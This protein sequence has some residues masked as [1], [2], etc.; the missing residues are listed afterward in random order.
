MKIFNKIKEKLKKF[1][2]SKLICGIILVVIGL[3]GVFTIFF[4]EYLQY[5]SIQAGGSY[6]PSDTLP[7]TCV[8][9][10]LGT[11]AS[12]CLYQLGLK[13]SRNKY[14]I[15]S[16]GVPYDIKNQDIG[17]EKFKEMIT[18][19]VSER[20]GDSLEVDFSQLENDNFE[21]NKNNDEDDLNG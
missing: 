14:N 15:D 18:N 21:N 11:F 7:V 10:I 6:I 3:T 4:H 5:L 16:D 20:F 17:Y 1:E 13:I 8:S 12:Y 2:F 9:V 19:F